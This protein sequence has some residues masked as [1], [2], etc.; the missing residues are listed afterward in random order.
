[1]I[2]F[3][4]LMIRRP[5]RSTRTD[6]LFPYTTLFR[7]HHLELG[8]ESFIPG[9]E[10]QLVGAAAGESR[11]VTVSFPDDYQASHLAGTEAV[12][13]VTVT[14]ICAPK[15]V[16][17]DAAFAQRFCL[18]ALS[19]LRTAVREPMQGA[20]PEAAGSKPQRSRGSDERR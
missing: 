4:F 19:A 5:P 8:S 9:F 13:D 2:I 11:D 12:F 1:M 16:A 14:E 6:T 3:F 17:I 7:S 10:G 18:D 20:F 15:S